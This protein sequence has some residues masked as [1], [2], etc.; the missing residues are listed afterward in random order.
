MYECIIYVF[1][2]MCCRQWRSV[3]K[4]R[5]QQQ[6]SGPGW[7]RYWRCVLSM[8]VSTNTHDQHTTSTTTTPHS[9]KTGQSL[10]SKQR[11]CIVTRLSP[12]VWLTLVTFLICH[13]ISYA[14]SIC[15]SLI[16]MGQR[17]TEKCRII[18]ISVNGWRWWLMPRG[19]LIN[20]EYEKCDCKHLS[21]VCCCG[22]PCILLF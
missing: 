13:D 12:R 20:Y 14:D 17:P 11:L 18:I 16:D 2:F 3:S 4:S 6:Q 8:T 10:H 7:R 21:H 22:W 9:L 1:F 15:Q 5:R 19:G